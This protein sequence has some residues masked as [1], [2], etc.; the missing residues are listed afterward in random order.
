MRVK[1]TNQVIALL[2][3]PPTQ[4]GLNS[5]FVDVSSKAL[6]PVHKRR[7]VSLGCSLAYHR[8]GCGESCPTSDGVETLL[9]RADEALNTLYGHFA[10]DPLSVRLI[11][12]HAA[13]TLKMGALQDGRQHSAR[14]CR[15][16]DSSLLHVGR[17]HSSVLPY[18]G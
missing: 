18:R 2:Q 8:T 16:V 14:R 1:C 17:S 4:H 7:I 15:T 12:T 10:R 9:K 13:R 6:H 11:S 3:V 5:S